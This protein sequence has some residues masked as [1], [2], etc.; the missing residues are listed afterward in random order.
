[1]RVYG[2]GSKTL[3]FQSASSR[4]RKEI[5]NPL[6]SKYIMAQ[7]SEI[8]VKTAFKIQGVRNTR[9]QNDG[10]NPPITRKTHYHLPL[11]RRICALTHSSTKKLTLDPA[12]L[13]QIPTRRFMD[14]GAPSRACIS[15]GHSRLER[16]VLYPKRTRS[17][18]PG[19]IVALHARR[20]MFSSH[21][22]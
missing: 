2:M 8:Q 10:M 15:N 14:G 7:G 16:D 12:L 20:W 6:A 4:N 18:G 21:S 5:E 22:R 17:V 1:M 9:Y 11:Q 19:G 13:R 3:L